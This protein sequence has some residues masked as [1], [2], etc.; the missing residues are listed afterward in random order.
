[1]PANT[2]A[3]QRECIGCAIVNGDLDPPGGIIDQTDTFVL[4]HDPEV[5]IPGFLIVAP[6][7]HIR[8]LNDFT[9]DEHTDFNTL[10]LRGRS[11]LSTLPN[12]ESV[13]IIQEERS[14]HFHCWL[15]PW[16]PWMTERFGGN[17]LDHIR[18]INAHA[19]EHLT[20]PDQIRS[21]LETV[22][23]FK[24]TSRNRQNKEE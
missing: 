2:P 11:L 23:Q 12:I 20:T 18:S 5:L 16:Y 14:S 1:M 13:T 15:F 21:I 17:S 3:T 10:L 24:T 7:R 4:H 9:K 6:R 22:E 19:K 8:S